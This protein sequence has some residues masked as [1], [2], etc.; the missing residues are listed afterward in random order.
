[1]LDSQKAAVFRDSPASLERMLL[2]RNASKPKTKNL[3]YEELTMSIQKKSLLSTLK[4]TKKAIVAS[5]PAKSEVEV[6]P[7]TRLA[8]KANFA[9][10]ANYASKVSHASKTRLASKTS[11]FASKFASKI[12]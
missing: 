9:S 5:T 8:K 2:R 12:V 10:K 4:T 7:S 3:A 6:A 11:K 1:L